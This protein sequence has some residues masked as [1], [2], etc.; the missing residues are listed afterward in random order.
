MPLKPLS[1]D[2]YENQWK[3]CYDVN[4]NVIIVKLCKI[5]LVMMNVDDET[6]EDEYNNDF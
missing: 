2:G 6:N 1:L 5:T 3:K 4:A